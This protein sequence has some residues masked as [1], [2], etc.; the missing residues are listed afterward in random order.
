MENPHRQLIETI[1]NDVLPNMVRIFESKKM[2]SVLDQDQYVRLLEENVERANKSLK[3][4]PVEEQGQY[5]VMIDQA[6]AINIDRLRKQH[7]VLQTV[8]AH[9]IPSEKKFN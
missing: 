2:D 8:T 3:M 1:C 4:L 6:Y 7:P 9:P 5:R